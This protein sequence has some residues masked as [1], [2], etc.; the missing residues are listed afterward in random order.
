MGMIA[1]GPA[2]L[3]RAASKVWE[4]TVLALI[5]QIAMTVPRLA[6]LVLGGV[7]GSFAAVAIYY[8][9]CAVLLARPLPR[10]KKRPPL[11]SMAQAALPLF[12]FNASWTFYLSANRWISSVLSSPHDLGLLSLERA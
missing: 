9:L 5:L 12:A 2:T 7:D 11:A 1:N 10:L 8:T 3:F 4:F 6:G